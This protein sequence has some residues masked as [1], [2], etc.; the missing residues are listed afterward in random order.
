MKQQNMNTLNDLMEMGFIHPKNNREILL[1]PMIR[2]VAVAELKPSVRNCWVLLDSLQEISL[3]HGLE[4]MNNKQVFHTVESIIATIRR[5][6]IAKYL[7]FLENVFQ[8]MDKYRYESGMQK[9]IEEL[10]TILADDTI[11]T[12]VDRA[13][14]LDCQA[15]LEKNDKKRIELLT[16]AIQILGEVHS[17]NAHLAANLYANLGA[18]YHRTG[19]MDLAKLHMEQGVHLLEEYDLTGYHDSVTQ[20]CNY[21]ALLTDLGEPQRAYSAL[22]KLSRTVKELNSDQCLDYGNIQQVMGSICVVKGDAAQAQLHHQRAMTIFEMVFEDEPAL[23][24]QKRQEIGKAT[25]VSKQ[26]NQK[27]LAR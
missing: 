21:A 19:H 12:S 15:A 13:C 24:E 5:D 17:G 6:D 10:G 7:L 18:L 20:T 27:L 9:V 3:M 22:V 23:L 16:E 1:H 2:E 26:K 25:L 11:G 4:F 14:L 8:Y